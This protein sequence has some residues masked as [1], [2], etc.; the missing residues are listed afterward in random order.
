MLNNWLSTRNF[1][2]RARPVGSIIGKA[3][4]FAF[5][6]FRLEATLDLVSNI[7]ATWFTRYSM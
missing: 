5:G 2:P 7:R 1:L 3:S 4:G 6:M